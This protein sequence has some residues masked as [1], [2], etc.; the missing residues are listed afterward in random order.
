M[1]TAGVATNHRI[2]SGIELN[3]LYKIRRKILRE[4]HRT[5]HVMYTYRTYFIF[6]F[7]NA[8]FLLTR[9]AQAHRNHIE[10]P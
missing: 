10:V 3:F 4:T 9:Q 5:V 7:S 1:T 8:L 6:S 2:L